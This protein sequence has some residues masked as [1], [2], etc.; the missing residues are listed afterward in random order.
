[1]K[2][3]F[4]PGLRPLNIKTLNIKLFQEISRTVNTGGCYK[5]GALGN[6]TDIK[7]GY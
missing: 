4:K 2:I 3:L 7:D 1:M 5:R 6:L